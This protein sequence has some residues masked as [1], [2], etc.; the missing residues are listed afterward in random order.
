[1]VILGMRRRIGLEGIPGEALG[2]G[3]VG[4]RRFPV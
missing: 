3:L 4:R 2:G 1:V